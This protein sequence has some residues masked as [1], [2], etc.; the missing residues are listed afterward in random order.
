MTSPAI[1]YNRTCN[2]L[3]RKAHSDL[4]ADS[5]QIRIYEERTQSDSNK[6]G[7]M[8]KQTERSRGDDKSLQIIDSKAI[9]VPDFSYTPNE[10]LW[11]MVIFS[12]HS[13]NSKG[14]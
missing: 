8:E 2:R 12:K 13:V 9:Q 14:G 1:N 10:N 6:N 5:R 4:I 11:V 3:E 7:A